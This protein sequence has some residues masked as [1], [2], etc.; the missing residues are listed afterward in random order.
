[1]E[2]C[3]NTE[4]NRKILC[5]KKFLH[6]VF[7]EKKQEYTCFKRKIFLGISIRPLEVGGIAQ[8]FNTPGVCKALGSR[9]ALLKTPTCSNGLS[10]SPTNYICDTF[11]ENKKFSF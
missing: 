9:E 8:C 7:G 2:L 1:M 4:E 6:S 5:L 3:R 11:R 10:V